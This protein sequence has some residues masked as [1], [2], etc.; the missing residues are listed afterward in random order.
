VTRRSTGL[1][2]SSRRFQ[3]G[4]QGRV[5]QLGGGAGGQLLVGGV[6]ALVGAADRAWGPVDADVGDEAPDDVDGGVDFAGELR[7][8]GVC[9]ATRLEV[10]LQVGE[11]EGM[12][13]LQAPLL[14]VDDG[15]AAAKDQTTPCCCWR[16]PCARSAGSPTTP[17]DPLPSG[18]QRSRPQSGNGEPTSMG[19]ADTRV[20]ASSPPSRTCPA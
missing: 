14:A 9:L 8:S 15:K 16:Y 6:A 13:T 20:L 10:V 17:G 12:D 1:D 5:A 4:L 7:E 3:V 11:A 18:H 19:N 2:S